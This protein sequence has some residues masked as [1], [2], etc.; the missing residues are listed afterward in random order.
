MWRRGLAAH[1]GLMNE[2]TLSIG[3][4]LDLTGDSLTG[5]I[6]HGEGVVTTFQGWI[7]LIAALDR[8][9]QA[10]EHTGGNAIHEG[11]RQ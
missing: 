2:H 3:L 11:E 8:L 7:G 4:E 10:H 6:A 1:R 9:V 5:R